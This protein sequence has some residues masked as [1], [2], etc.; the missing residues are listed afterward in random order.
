[1]SI[2]CPECRGAIVHILS[3]AN[4]KRGRR[5]YL[6]TRRGCTECEHEWTEESERTNACAHGV[7]FVLPCSPCGRSWPSSGEEPPL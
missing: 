5:F 2:K 6:A 4:A 7:A 3:V 1:M